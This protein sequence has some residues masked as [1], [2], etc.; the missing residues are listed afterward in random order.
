[1]EM[2]GHQGLSTSLFRDNSPTGE[3]EQTLVAAAGGGAA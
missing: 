2:Q 1:M 3:Q